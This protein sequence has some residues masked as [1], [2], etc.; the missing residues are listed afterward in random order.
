LFPEGFLFFIAF[1]NTHLAYIA[2]EFEQALL[3]LA[4]FCAYRERC[5]REVRS[6][7]TEWELP[8]ALQERLIH[9]LKQENYL[10]DERFAMAYV[11]S[12]FRQ[13]HWGKIKLRLMLQQKGLPDELIHRALHSIDKDEYWQTLLE[14]AEKKAAQLA[15]KPKSATPQ[16]SIFQFLA[17]KGFEADLVAEAVRIVWKIT[18]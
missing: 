16:R 2:M 13:Q 12:K 9:Y 4:A 10:D 17:R 5:S 14:L 8:D 15:A 3:K 18:R 6:K 11:R 1:P 7:M